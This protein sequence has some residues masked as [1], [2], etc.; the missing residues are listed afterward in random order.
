MLEKRIVA[1]GFCDGTTMTNPYKTTLTYSAFTPWLGPDI[2]LHDV[3]PK[4]EILKGLS[5]KD[6]AVSSRGGL[7]IDEDAIL[8]A[9]DSKAPR[10]EDLIKACN[11]LGVSDVGSRTDLINRLEELLLYKD[12][13]PK[14]FV[15]LQN[16]GGGVLHMTCVHSVVYYQ[17]A[18]WWQESARDH[19]DALLSFKHPPTVYVSDIAGRV[20]RHVNN[21]TNQQFFQPH[22]GRLCANTDENIQAALEKSLD[23]QFPWITSV[24]FSSGSASH[25]NH[26]KAKCV[27]R[28]SSV[29]PVTGTSA[30][31]SLYD[32]FHQKNQKR[33]EEH[34]RSLKLVPDLAVLVNSSAA[35]QLNRELSSSRYS[36]CQMNDQHYMFTLRLYF[37]LHNININ[38]KYTKTME[39][40]TKQALHVDITGKLRFSSY[41]E[42][43]QIS[44]PADEYEE[45]HHTESDD[46]PFT[47]TMFPIAP[48]NKDKLLE[49]YTGQRNQRQT[50]TRFDDN[51]LTI[52]DLRS[53]CPQHLL[54]A[55][56]APNPRL[57]WLT[58]DVVNSRVVQIASEGPNTVALST[59][60]F[61]IWH[62][63]WQAR[64][65]IP[66][67][68]IASLKNT[69]K[70]LWPRIVGGTA[71]PEWGNHY[72]LWV[73]D[74][75]G[76]ELRVYDSMSASFTIESDDMDMLRNIFRQHDSLNGWKVS[77]AQSWKQNDSVNCGVFVCTMAEM[78]MRA[79]KISEDTLHYGQI[80][81]LRLYHASC[82]VRNMVSEDFP[83]RV[84]RNDQGATA[85]NN[86]I[87][88][89]ISACIFQKSGKRTMHSHIKRVE[90]IQCDYCDGWLH[91]DC[92]G[93]TVS[94]L[95]KDA[96]FSCG[97]HLPMP[98]PYERT[99]EALRK[100]L[101]ADL[102]EDRE[103]L[104]LQDDLLSGT[105]KSHRQFLYNN[106]T[107]NVKMKAMNERRFCVFDE[108]QTTAIIEKAFTVLKLDKREIRN[109][110]FV[111]DV[112]TPEVTILI[113]KKLEGFNRYQAEMTFARDWDLCKDVEE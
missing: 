100:G 105:V 14:M 60:T 47:V 44:S 74:I 70:V 94:T 96:P 39:L 3:V 107:F 55:E 79:A 63:E 103:I 48:D 66:D 31:Y 71:G 68:E 4:T 30:R 23:V 40:L 59:N 102:I 106:P 27:N 36:L 101:V 72:I 82:L 78:D 49:L 37:H 19:G 11:A 26:D 85:H 90:W 64:K 80:C 42:K 34:L 81:H 86:C 29:H 7:N 110:S 62:R 52:R 112:I 45:E 95:Y 33:P 77:S 104:K 41:A 87:A 28:F 98:Y 108:K 83:S 46:G 54:D 57:P 67:E 111:L 99:H 58:D 43:S 75:P 22:D 10:R 17:S 69:E 73:F 9:L 38:Q 56:I 13:Y 113:L 89:D 53:I 51:P 16:T 88:Q 93:V 24:G 65:N 35:E 15:K 18:L 50:I 1:S 2:R 97:C 5:Q 25:D 91:S 92:A 8:Q 76:K 109:V 61:I 20:A 21:R 6:Q 32:R 84:E 12:L